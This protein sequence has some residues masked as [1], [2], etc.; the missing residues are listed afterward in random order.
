[1]LNPPGCS[2]ALDVRPFAV[3]FNGGQIY[4]G[5]V[6]SAESTITQAA[7]N[8]DA[9][10]LQAYVYSVNPTTLNFS[11]SPVFQIALDYPRRCTDSAQLGPG[12]CFSAAWRSW[13]PV[14]RNIGTVVGVGPPNLSRG[15]YP[16]PLLTDLAFDRGNLILG[17]RD[18]A[19]DQFGNATLDNPAESVLRYYG[20]SAGD[21]LRA[22]GDTVT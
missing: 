17:L 14:H 22:C 15:I 13:S 2:N 10:K 9:T 5:M 19:G 1:P 12:N 3:N 18:R 4:V 20:V 16:Q 11:A 21:A 8:G 7:P 6:C